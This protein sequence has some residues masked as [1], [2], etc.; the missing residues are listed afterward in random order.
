MGKKLK[1]FLAVCAGTAAAWALAVKPRIWNKPDLSEIQRYDFAHRGFHDPEKKIPENSMAAFSAA[2]E[3]GYG[4][5]MDVRI[6]RDGVPVVFA[7]ARLDRLT[8]T[9]GTIENSTLEDLKTLCLCGTEEK[10]PTLAE[11]L[12]LIDGQVPVIVELQV[13][14]GNHDVLSDLTCE[15]L[16]A[17][18]GVFAVESLDFR[19]LRWYKKQR[20]EYIRGQKADYAHRSGYRILD[21]I[22]DFLTASLLL[23]FLTAPDYIATN[24]DYRRSPSLFICR[25][26]YRIPRMDW[27]ITTLEDYEMVRTDGSIV[28]FDEIEP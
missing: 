17:Y 19:V 24:I 16:D 1:T 13:A 15:V 27:L 26:L 2:I 20:N 9:N 5:K 10:I 22:L 8:G 28:V 4:I 7:D 3:H 18:E 12:E 23:N 25:F 14:D 11:A 6:T 21:M